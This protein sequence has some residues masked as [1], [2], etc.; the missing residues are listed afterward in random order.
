MTSKY[1]GVYLNAGKWRADANHIYLGRFDTEEEAAKR[2]DTYVLLRDG[3]AAKTNGLVRYEEVSNLDI[4]HFTKQREL[5]QNIY[6]NP[7][8][9]FIVKLRHKGKY[10]TRHASNLEEA[11]G[12]LIN[13]RDSLQNQE[14]PSIV[15][16][17]QGVAVVPVLDGNWQVRGEAMVPDEMWHDCI[18]HKWYQK[19][20]GCVVT[21]CSQ[22]KNTTL[23]RFVCCVSSDLKVRYKDRNPLNCQFDNLEVRRRN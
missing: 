17:A 22:G 11:V 16:N 8:G 2:Y 23:W 3:P 15:R 1:L 7:D 10:I 5:P 13:I 12:K 14:K 9:G 18:R 6:H 19:A 20:A 4:T 21:G